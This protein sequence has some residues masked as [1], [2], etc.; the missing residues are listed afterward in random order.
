MQRPVATWRRVFRHGRAVVATAI[1]VLASAIGEALRPLS[2]DAGRES[3]ARAFTS[4]D[5]RRQPAVSEAEQAA[6]EPYASVE[7]VD[8]SGDSYRRNTYRFIAETWHGIW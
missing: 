7:D 2:L 1:V 3:D 8:Q 5:I 6:W 4:L